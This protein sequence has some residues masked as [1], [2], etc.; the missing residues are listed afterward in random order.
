MAANITAIGSSGYSIIRNRPYSDALSLT[1]TVAKSYTI[2]D[3]VYYLSFDYI[4]PLTTAL[5]VNMYGATAAIPSSDLTGGNNAFKV[6]PSAIYSVVPGSTIS[7]VSSADKI[8][9]IQGYGL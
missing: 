3:G 4:A 7:L 6:W 5:W 9:S 8:L 2:P 1:A